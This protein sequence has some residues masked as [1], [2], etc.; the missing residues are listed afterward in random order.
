MPKWIEKL[1]PHER[2]HLKNQGVHT[3]KQFKGMRAE[4]HRLKR[5]TA[6][7][8]IRGMDCQDCVAIE[9]KLKGGK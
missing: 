1:T 8:S 3:L 5:L 9:N 7:F 2:E 4:M 6:A